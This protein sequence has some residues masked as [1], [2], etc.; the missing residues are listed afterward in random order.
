MRV[1]KTVESAIVCAVKVAL[2]SSSGMEDGRKRRPDQH[3]RLVSSSIMM[4]VIVGKVKDIW[5]E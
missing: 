5:I 3:A 1:G 4:L 2:S